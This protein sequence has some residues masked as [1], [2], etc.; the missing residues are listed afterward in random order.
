MKPTNAGNSKLA[1][2][3]LAFLLS[4]SVSAMDAGHTFYTYSDARRKTT[5]IIKYQCPVCHGW[6]I[7]TTPDAVTENNLDNLPTCD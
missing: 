4:F 7:K 2:V 1:G 3:A 5:E 6:H